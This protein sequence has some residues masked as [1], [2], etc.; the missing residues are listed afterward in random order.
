MR[1]V[2]VL[3]VLVSSV[4]VAQALKDH[5]ACY[6]MR[7][8]LGVS[9]VVDFTSDLGVASGCRLGGA[10]LVCDPTSRTIVSSNITVTPV[11]G[12]GLLDGRIC[13][14]VRCKPP[15]PASVDIADQFGT[16]TLTKLRP[17]LLCTP[18]VS[19][20]PAPLMDNLDHLACY[21]AT[22]SISPKAVVNVGPVHFD[23]AFGCS[24]ARSKL[25]CV[26]ASTTVENVN[27]SPE[28]PIGG[29]GMDDPRVCYTLRCP[30]PYPGPQLMSDRFGSRT[31]T[32][33]APKFLCGPSPT[34]TTTTTTITSGSTTPSTLPSGDAPL[35]CQRAIEAGGMVY[36]N[37]VLDQIAACTAPGGATSLASCMASAG[38]ASAL[39][40]IR[41]QWGSDTAA[42]CTGVD[43]RTVLGYP[44]TCGAAPSTCTFASPV[45]DAAGANNDVL[46]CLACRTKEQLTTSAVAM[47]AG[48]DAAEP[49]RDAIGNGSLD[50]LRTT[51]EAAHACVDQA[52]VTSVAACWAPAFIGW[53]AQAVSAC[54][55]VDPFTTLGY[56]KFCSAQPPVA[57]NSYAAHA[58]P[59]S[60]NDPTVDTAGID[61][62]LLDCATCQANEGALG[63][64]RDLFGANLCCIGGTCNKVLTRYACRRAGGTPMRYRITTMTA[65][66]SANA[67]GIATGPDSSLY[68]GY[69]F[70][71]TVRRVTPAGMVSTAANTI[72]FVRGVAVDTAGN[73]YTADG[74]YHTITKHFVGGGSTIIAGSINMPGSTGD[75]G[76][77]T[78]AKI[79][80]PDGVE[81]DTAG[82]VYFTESGVLGALCGSGIV[83]S[84]RV[85]MVDTAGIIHTV[86]G[87]GGLGTGGEGGP[88]TSAGLS[89]PYGLRIG[90]D[91]S[92]Y[93]GE[94]W[95]MRVM[96]LTGGTLTRVAGVPLGLVGSHSGFGGPAVNA[97]FYENCGI[98]VDPDGNVLI[99]MME[100]NRV[101]LVD[102]LG[103]VITIGGTGEGPGGGAGLGDGGPAVLERI[104]TPEDVAVA[105]DGTVYVSDLGNSTIRILKREPY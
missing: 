27:V 96:R 93:I 44:E 89:M 48:Q 65:T 53:R 66:D 88:A 52:G 14:R 87:N 94:A 42:P 79:V 92:L 83:P 78:A 57:P 90:S 60:F 100:D 73:V 105:P 37:V 24:V 16:R 75:E 19:G 55:G 104:N 29:T 97:R 17:R 3:I 11:F 2:T 74:C 22:D 35:A 68:L 76:L 99:A 21:K 47:Y 12:R 43:L 59:C 77:A 49:C 102:S 45:R 70:N 82:N 26:P 10:K 23:G 85:R 95:G 9:G 33:V 62:D 80:M 98:A 39:A 61:N 30:R 56:G 101:A 13:Y 6:R 84:E 91:G 50:V 18:A 7:D 8:P 71:S 32:G 15:Y 86:A 72:G 67:H 51:L 38:V 81:V 63:V 58:F 34:S 54:A 41:T 28:L 46:D 31:L 20:P 5:Q 1:T 25:V 40:P 103:S 69:Y 64:A 36:A 4:G